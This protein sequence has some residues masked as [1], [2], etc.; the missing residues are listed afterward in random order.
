MYAST[1]SVT[2]K[3][4]G[5]VLTALYLISKCT[6]AYQLAPIMELMIWILAHVS[7]MISGQEKTVL[8]V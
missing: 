5:K 8:K 7:V 3:L 1:G 2:A 6:S 4:V